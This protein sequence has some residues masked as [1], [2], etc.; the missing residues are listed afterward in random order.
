AGVFDVPAGLIMRV[1]N[2]EIE[3]LVRSLTENNPYEP[4]EKAKLNTGLYCETVM[5]T[6]APLHVPNAL[7][8]PDWQNNPDIELNMISYI[9]M[10]LIWPDSSV[11]G[12]VCILDEKQL[13]SSINYLKLLKQIKE[14]IE[15][16]F[17]MLDRNAEL[18]EARKTAEQANSAKSAFLANMSHELRTPMNAIIGY[19]ELLMEE[20]D[21]IGEDEF[22]SDL[23][24]INTAGN[25]LLSLIND[26]LDL[27]KIESG[28]MEVFAEKVDVG[29]L[30]DQVCDT[31]KPLMSKNNNQLKI[32][33]GDLPGN[34][35]QDV[36]KLRQSLLNLLS[37]AAKF[38]QD[39]T[40]T[41]RAG[42]E[43]Q[44]DGDWL[45]FSVSDTGI[46]IAPEK[47]DQIFQEFSQ[48]D[49]AI[50]R[51]YGGTGLGLAISRRF[52]RMLGGDLTVTSQPGRGS[53]FLIRVP[54]I[55]SRVNTT[56]AFI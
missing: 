40:I 32:E 37:N 13:N 10:P 2:Q 21:E 48:V 42:Y 8:D 17:E 49:A 12:T 52:S 34:A 51:D 41:L 11:F 50:T 6:R 28:K 39:G 18:K 56:K 7:E 47:L 5:S 14:T 30:I 33:R 44:D 22:V 23:V 25:Y 27:S 55:F 36:T 29:N 3:V 45:T 26:V 16:D 19:S 9:G 43:A 46:G 53:T 15:L 20:A 1:H 24:K 54:V 31:A 35:H 38:T 4:G